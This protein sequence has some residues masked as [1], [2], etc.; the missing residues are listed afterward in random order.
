MRGQIRGQVKG[1]VRGQKRGQGRYP[2]RCKRVVWHETRRG[3][4][5]R[6]RAKLSR[7]RRAREGA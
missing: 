1:E 3:V 2:R 7:T 6:V 4:K 5:D